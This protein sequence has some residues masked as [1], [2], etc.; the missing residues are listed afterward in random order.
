MTVVG[1]PQKSPAFF[2]CFDEYEPG[3]VFPAK[4]HVHP[5]KIQIS[6]IRVLTLRLKIHW[7]L[8]YSPAV[9]C[10]D[11]DQTAR[12][13]RLIWVFAGRTC[14]LV[15]NALS[16][17]CYNWACH[18]KKKL[19]SVHMRAVKIQISQYDQECS[20]MLLNSTV[21]S[22]FESGQRSPGS[23]WWGLRWLCMSRR[24]LFLWR[25]QF[26]VR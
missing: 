1:E 5:E 9:S 14:S 4:L 10:E 25:A 22:D 20:W 19:F 21:F 3:T 17:S 13:R 6:L 7:I 12:M 16:R 23:D 11:F 2:I 18:E 15:E 24:S 8:G 26:R